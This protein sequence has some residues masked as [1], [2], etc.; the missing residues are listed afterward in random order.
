M[1]GVKPSSA[2]SA[3]HHRYPGTALCFQFW[4]D[5]QRAQVLVSPQMSDEAAHENAQKDD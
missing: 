1:E 5:W 2:I 4:H 3:R